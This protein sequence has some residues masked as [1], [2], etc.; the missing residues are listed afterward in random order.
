MV[1]AKQ[2]QQG[3]MKIVNGQDIFFCLEAEGVGFAETKWSTN[4][5][6]REPAGKAEGVVVSTICT[7]L[8]HRHPAELRAKNNQG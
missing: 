2:M 6:S 4:P 8:E 3:R 5:R 7:S 1:E